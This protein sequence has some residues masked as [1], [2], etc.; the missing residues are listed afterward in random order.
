VR[1]LP[2]DLPDE[3]AALVRAH[4]IRRRY[5]HGDV[6]VFQGDPSASL[7]TIES[8]HATVSVGTEGGD[9]TTL[10]I[11]GPGDSFG[12]LAGIVGS[13]ARTATVTAIDD[14]EAS[15][16]PH[17]D[18]ARIR[19][20]HPAVDEVL[21][22]ALARRV[23]DLGDRLV[24]T[25]YESVGR[26][27]ARRL[28]ETAELFRDGDGAVVPI[29]QEDLA[30]MTGAT[31]PTVNQVLGRLVD[32]GIVSLARGRIIVTSMTGLRSFVR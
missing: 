8:G 24:Q 21:V 9:R 12:E 19:S 25:L 27:C 23:E 30:G 32:D 7:F 15:I 29:T 17:A 31:R 3:V 28:L 10:T 5:R 6:L 1:F 20:A 16:L 22:V 26:R 14:L 2:D 13:G 4:T 18:F 11:L